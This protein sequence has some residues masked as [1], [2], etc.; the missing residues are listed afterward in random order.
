M[1]FIR[2][3]DNNGQAW[4]ESS[5]DPKM[6]NTLHKAFKNKGFKIIRTKLN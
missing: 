2:Y 3:R 4:L 5:T 1:Y 6:I